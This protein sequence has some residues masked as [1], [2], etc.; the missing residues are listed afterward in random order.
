[1]SSR[2]SAFLLQRRSIDICQRVLTCSLKIGRLTVV[3]DKGKFAISSKDKDYQF[4]AG[5]QI[6]QVFKKSRAKNPHAIFQLPV[7]K[8]NGQNPN[9]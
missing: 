5:A 1:M 7:K 4:A 3:E 9:S 6:C 8:Q 2:A